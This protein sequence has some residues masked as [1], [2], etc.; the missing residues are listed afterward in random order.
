VSR[1]AAFAFLLWVAAL[2]GLAAL[3]LYR[4]AQTLPL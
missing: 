2:A 3:I 1:G 4:V